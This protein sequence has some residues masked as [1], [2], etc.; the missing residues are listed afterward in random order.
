M[1]QREV[2]G[3]VASLARLLG[4]PKLDRAAELLAPHGLVFLKYNT[5]RAYRKGQA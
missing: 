3:A 1:A 4:I 2:A 5:A